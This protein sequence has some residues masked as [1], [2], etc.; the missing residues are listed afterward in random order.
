MNGV[1]PLQQFPLRER[2]P[3]YALLSLFFIVWILMMFASANKAPGVSNGIRFILE[4]V[5]LLAVAIGTVQMRALAQ[6]RGVL[7]A[8]PMP[9][10]LWRT[11]VRACVI[12]TSLAWAFL[13]VAMGVLLASPGSNMQWPGAVALLSSGLAIGATCVLAQYSMGPKNLGRFANAAAAALLLSGVYFGTGAVLGWFVALP[14]PVLALL[15]LSW[16]LL[17]AVLALGSRRPLGLQ[18][19]SPALSHKKRLAAM[20][21]K[22]QRYSPLD[23]TWRDSPTPSC[24]PR[25]AA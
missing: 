13:S 4:A 23:P 24:A 14:L 5:F 3:M 15:T 2:T 8:Q 21:R 19:G 16:P 12:E 17:G 18:P 25:A 11:W 9:N 6:A 20:A 1:F 22:I 10:A 7:A